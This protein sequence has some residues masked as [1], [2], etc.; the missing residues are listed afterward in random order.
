[1]GIIVD[2]NGNVVGTDDSDVMYSPQATA[3]SA[4]ASTPSPLAPAGIDFQSAFA[5]AA[6]L[7]L[8]EQTK[9]GLGLT[10][11]QDII[12]SRTPDKF[13]DALE[14]A[15]PQ[16]KGALEIIRGN[17]DLKKNFHAAFA[18][19]PSMIEG[20]TASMAGS[21]AD[22]QE[23]ESLLQDPK[24]QSR[25]SFVLGKIAEKPD[26]KYNYRTLMP[27]ADKDTSQADKI[28]LMT[29]MGYGIMDEMGPQ[30]WLKMATEF[31]RNPGQFIHDLPEMLGLSP[32]DAEEFR[33]N[34]LVSWAMKGAGGLTQLALGG[35]EGDPEGYGGHIANALESGTQYVQSGDM[36]KDATRLGELYDKMTSPASMTALDPEKSGQAGSHFDPNASGARTDGYKPDQVAAATPPAPVVPTHSGPAHV[37]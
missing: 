23:L 4:V 26:D 18:K 10:S 35:I 1:M 34:P 17:D 30:D 13:I 7:S 24:N 25:I 14:Q 15:A 20:F 3:P 28:K 6:G 22:P 5:D 29:E 11:T 36:E 16:Y 8:W 2:A 37:M 32:E 9:Y 27:L 33:N 21:D 12:A 19:D 31:F